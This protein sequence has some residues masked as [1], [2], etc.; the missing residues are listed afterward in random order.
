ME[1]AKQRV[2]VAAA[3]KKDEKK[4]KEAGGKPRQPLRPLLSLQRG[5]PTGVMT[6]RLKRPPSILGIMPQRK[7]PPLSQAMVRARG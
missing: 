6:I 1:S 2:R 5:I 4:A 7:N 3:H